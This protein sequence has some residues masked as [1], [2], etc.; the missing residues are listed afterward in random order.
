M[1]VRHECVHKSA[2]GGG[3][4]DSGAV[5]RQVT[6][7]SSRDHDKILDRHGPLCSRHAVYELHRA[8]AAGS[9]ATITID[10]W[11]ASDAKG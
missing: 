11:E 7:R 1:T 2:S 4:C 3:D 10:R 8:E 6:Y 5:D 9:I